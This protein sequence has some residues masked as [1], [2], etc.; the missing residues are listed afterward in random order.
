[1][2]C[3]APF[4]GALSQ[5]LCDSS[6]SIQG[7]HLYRNVSKPHLLCLPLLLSPVPTPPK[8]SG[9]CQQPFRCHGHCPAYPSSATSYIRVLS[10]QIQSPPWEAFLDSSQPRHGASGLNQW[11]RN[12]K[13][14]FP[15]SA[16]K[17]LVWDIRVG[18]RESAFLGS[19]S[20]NV[21]VCVYIHIY[22]CVY[23]KIYLF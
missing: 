19:P 7:A 4:L 11:V 18:V 21:S 6:D 8:P 10:T 13:C 3:S 16:P 15:G 12:G 22:M 1:M 9:V 2:R 20:V 23:L 14:R 17:N 5:G